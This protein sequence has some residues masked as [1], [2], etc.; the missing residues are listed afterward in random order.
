MTQDKANL[1]PEDSAQAESFSATGMFRRA[2][3]P[4]PEEP[5]SP[6]APS[7]E[8][9]PAAPST[10]RETP[11]PV[12]QAGEFT[13]LFQRVQPFLPD[14][15]ATP[16]TPAATGVPFTPEPGE[17]T[18]I[19]RGRPAGRPSDARRDGETS[20]TGAVR[21]FS[22]PG[23]S[24]SA[25]AEG[26]VTQLLR[27]PSPGP[28]ASPA[29]AKVEYES[30]LQARAAAPAAPSPRITNLLE[31]LSTR[32]RSADAPIAPELPPISPRAASG[33][34][35]QFIQKLADEDSPAPPAPP[36]QSEPIPTSSGPGEFT[37]MV[38]R[39]D[40][41]P[42][43]TAPSVPSASPATPPGRLGGAPIPFA[44]TLPPAP[45]AAPALA[46]KPAPPPLPAPPP[47]KKT[48]LEA[49]APALLAMNT[50]LL[51]AVLF[52]LILL[53]RSR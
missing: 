19:F 15:A 1:L 22:S 29:H 42:E 7:A 26:S 45:V 6:K 31:S 28:S 30:L 24:D 34:V 16:P 17:F 35:T 23:P 41:K 14:A 53:L 40:E 47:Q 51:L 25:A 2:F 44:A 10:A 8:P 36:P 20:A 37:R 27:A 3:A 49:M 9:S 32:D 48:K 5:A 50:V 13:H 39:L 52:V 11:P 38:A 4:N 18:R 12:S 46:A 21:G 33:G 43:L